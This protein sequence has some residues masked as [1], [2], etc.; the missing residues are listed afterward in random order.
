[1]H[2]V[3]G[4][5]YRSIVENVGKLAHS[6]PPPVSAILA[7]IALALEWPHGGANTIVIAGQYVQLLVLRAG[8]QCKLV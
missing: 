2:A 6:L 1:V 7:R 4:G 5:L 3:I 8:L